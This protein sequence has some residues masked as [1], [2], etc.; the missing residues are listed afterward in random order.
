[1]SLEEIKQSV[2]DYRAAH[3]LRKVACVQGNPQ[4]DGTFQC[5]INWRQGGGETAV[6]HGT[7]PPRE[8]A[9]FYQWARYGL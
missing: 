6:V 9:A 5:V 1:M 7:F 8:K 4:P 3:P 2:S